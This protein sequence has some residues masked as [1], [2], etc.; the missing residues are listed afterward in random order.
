MTPNYSR[1]A[2]RGGHEY[3]VVRLDPRRRILVLDPSGGLLQASPAAIQ[4]GRELILR[5]PR[6][7][8]EGESGLQIE[9]C[10]LPDAWV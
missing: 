5:Q 8:D 10:A 3:A 4:E 2:C 7:I 1:T 6:S 9:A